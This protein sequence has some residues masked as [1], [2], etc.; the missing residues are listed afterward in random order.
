MTPR[1]GRHTVIDVD[2]DVSSDSSPDPIW[3]DEWDKEYGRH[4]HLVHQPR[5]HSRASAHHHRELHRHYDIPFS[6]TH[7]YSPRRRSA[8]EW[9]TEQAHHED[10]RDERRG[11]SVDYHVVGGPRIR[12]DLHNTIYTSGGRNTVPNLNVDIH[13]HNS[14]HDYD[15]SH[16]H[17]HSHSRSP[18]GHSTV[19]PPWGQHSGNPFAVPFAPA[20]PVQNN[21]PYYYQGPTTTQSGAA[22]DGRAYVNDRFA[23][24][25]RERMDQRVFV[26][27]GDIG[28]F[29]DPYRHGG[30]HYGH[31]SWLHDTELKRAELVAV[32]SYKVHEHEAEEARRLAVRDAKLEIK[33][34]ENEIED[35]EDK[36][37]RKYEGKLTEMKKAG[38]EALFK[39][40][41]AEAKKAEQLKLARE[42]W[43]VE[44][45]KKTQEAEDAR[46]AWEAEQVRKE[47][48]KEEERR[49][50]KVKQ[51]EEE[52]KRKDDE[53]KLKEKWEADER[54]RK[55]EAKKKEEATKAKIEADEKKKKDEAKKKEDEIKAKIEKELLRTGLSVGA[56]EDIIED[57]R[58]LPKIEPVTRRV[59]YEDR[60]HRWGEYFEPWDYG[61]RRVIRVHRRYVTPDTLRVYDLPYE[62]DH[63]DPEYIIIHREYDNPGIDLKILIEHTRHHGYFHRSRSRDYIPVVV[64][65]PYR[66]KYLKR[67]HSHRRRWWP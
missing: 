12:E 26:H 34:H 6:E 22:A 67:A 14:D 3:D 65:D 27:N 63:T 17:N 32:D 25:H 4:T 16:S 56:A 46:K 33:E 23:A 11:R 44:Q 5:S 36:A 48:K 37:V 10:E 51:T 2:V 66:G 38:D 35:A 7:S 55:E 39:F 15:H 24:N 28:E 61:D 57:R 1:R 29:D 31:D 60:S 20:A 49:A 9:V 8:R 43:E 41:Q 21:N 45:K 54:E 59:V 42:K 53:K 18:G 52:Q 58:P 64:D 13:N 62:F 30:H 47:E 40:Q 50:W 19:W